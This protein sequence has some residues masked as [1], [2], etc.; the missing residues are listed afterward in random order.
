MWYL[1]FNIIICKLN[2]FYGGLV[3]RIGT[4]NKKKV[5]KK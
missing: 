5:I 2:L 3:G 4:E 1:R